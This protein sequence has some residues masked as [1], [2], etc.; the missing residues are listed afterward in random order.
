MARRF[1][2]GICT[3]Q[4]MGWETTVERWQLLERLGFES[5]WLCDHLVQPSRP[6]G[7]YFEGWTLLAALAART[8]RIRI[9]ILVS[10]NTFRHPSVLAKQAVTVDH[11]ANGRLEVGLGA[12]WYEPEHS[13]F[14]LPFPERGELVSRFEE[15]VQVV[16]RLLRQDTSSFDG[17]Y[18]QLREARSRPPTVQRPRPPFLIGA[19]G[20]RML[21]IAARYA[22]TW[23]ASG[24]PEE[25]RE[26]N[27]MLDRFCGEIGRDPQTLDRS[28]YF[29]VPRSSNDPWASVE[30]FRAA[31]EPYVE[32]GIN[33]FILDQPPDDRLGMLERVAAEIVPSFAG[34][35]PVAVAAG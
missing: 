6:Q 27:R 4:N 22:D 23:N 15:A 28:L 24:T 34:R 25:I 9:G 29:W 26:R 35:Q 18:Y 11:I 19:K 13:M 7:P 2:F 14:G 21:K 16:D 31:I 20:P 10:S 32:A 12:G 3:D 33:Q 1:S 30:D 8:E 5:A 17:R